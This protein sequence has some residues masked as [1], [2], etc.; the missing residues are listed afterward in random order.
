M[1][2]I[3]DWAAAEA[4][5]TALTTELNALAD[6]SFGAASAAIDNTTGTRYDMIGLE[7]NLASLSPAAGGY[8]DVWAEYSLD[9]TNYADHGKAL[10]VGALLATFQLDTAAATAQRLPVAVARI[11]P[12]KFKLALRNNAGVALGATGNTLKYARLVG[13]GV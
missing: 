5:Q 4:I 2:T 3:F 1:A 11:L 8:V 12:L 10:Q 6:G 7:V 9:G 13:E